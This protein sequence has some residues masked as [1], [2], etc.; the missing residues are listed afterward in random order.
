[1]RVLIHTIPFSF[2]FGTLLPPGIIDAEPVTTPGLQLSL[3]CYPIFR[4]NQENIYTPCIFN[5][6][7]QAEPCFNNQTAQRSGYT[8]HGNLS[9]AL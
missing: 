1:M 4:V 7:T 9:I 6:R 8:T 3:Q 5:E 2:H